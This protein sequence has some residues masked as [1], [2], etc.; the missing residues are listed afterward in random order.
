MPFR[1]VVKNPKPDG[2][3]SETNGSAKS[4][5]RQFTWSEIEATSTI[6]RKQNGNAPT[7]IVINDKVYDVGG[8][9]VKWH[10]GGNVVLSQAGMDATGAFDVFHQE[11]THEIMAN[12]YVGDL[13]PGQVRKQSDFFNDVTRLRQEFEAKGYYESSKLY[14]LFKLLFNQSMW[15]ISIAIMIRFPT[16]L[17]AVFV[18]GL[19]MALFFQQSG[20]LSHDFLH[21]Q[22]F[23]NRSLNK[24]V[25]YFTG[26]VCQG[27]LFMA[28][29]S[30][31]VS[32]WV[33]KHSTHHSTPNVHNADPDIDTMPILAWS[34]HALELFTD[35]DDATLAKFL[36]KYQPYLY[37]PI[38]S[39]ARLSWCHSSIRYVANNPNIANRFVENAT[40]AL[41]WIWYLG[42]AT[43]YLSTFGALL[44]FV[45]SQGGCG[46]MLASVFSLNHNGMPVLDQQEAREHD[47]YA[48][49]AITGRD[50]LPS[51]AADF[52]TGGLNYQI[53]HHMFPSIPRHNFHLIKEQTLAL[54]KKHNVPYHATTF[55]K[56]TFEVLSRL[57]DISKTSLEMK[58]QK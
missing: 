51:I 40:L 26:N 20:W 19:I 32:W 22:V 16:N 28:W 4:N 37:F 2:H 53:E 10:P 25:G 34:E 21:N 33:N 52:F 50:V 30:F 31:S 8:D 35:V 44:W 42:F 7:Y 55:T 14:Y 38:L 54:C 49:Q 12:F 47:F 29:T 9:F 11:A 36:V 1:P 6:K 57:A 46:L 23:K 3:K 48:L 15:A 56:G 45:T 13:A 18:S 58:K 43:R 27:K 41:H 39:F 5:T 24:A 17:F